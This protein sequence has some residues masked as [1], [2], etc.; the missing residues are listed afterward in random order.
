MLKDSI[1]I[2]YLK[3]PKE[4]IWGILRSIDSSGLFMEGINI[5]SFDEWIQEF[6]K[7]DHSGA[8]LS[9]I[10]FPASRIE[11]ILMDEPTGKIPS[12][13]QRFEEKTGK[14]VSEFSK[15]QK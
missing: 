4:R 14:S 11:K 6:S 13:S 8:S 7:S 9:K 3:D 1:V 5:D 10:F 12:L 15:S 2:A